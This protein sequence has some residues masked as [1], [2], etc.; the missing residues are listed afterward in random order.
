[1]DISPCPSGDK[2]GGIA[3]T[4]PRAQEVSDLAPPR[5]QGTPLPCPWQGTPPYLLQRAAPPCPLA[6]PAAAVPVG[7]PRPVLTLHLR[8]WGRG[9]S[10]SWHAPPELACPPIPRPGTG[11]GW[12]SP[13]GRAAWGRAEVQVECSRSQVVPCGQQ[14]CPSLQ[15]TACPGQPVSVPAA[16]LP[17]PT[18]PTH[19]DQQQ[20][21]QGA[22][23]LEVPSLG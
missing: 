8:S 4:P 14:C 10:L 15:H 22:L 6:G 19:R 18:L 11:R 13:S 5:A 3:L 7:A 16:A 1:M 17:L 2:Q 12:S 23:L 9:H 20:Q 21:G